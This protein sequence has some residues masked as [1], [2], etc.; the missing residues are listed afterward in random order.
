VNVN[1]D[2]SEEAGLAAAAYEAGIDYPQL[3]EAIVAA[4]MK[5]VRV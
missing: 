3:I 1:P 5:R 2:I 4:G